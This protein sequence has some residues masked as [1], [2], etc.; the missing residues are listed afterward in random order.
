MK[1]PPGNMFEADR[2]V[3]DAFK[4][5]VVHASW[6][7]RR[8]LESALDSR[9]FLRRRATALPVGELTASRC[10]APYGNTASCLAWVLSTPPNLARIIGNNPP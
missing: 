10:G 3:V 9:S 7:R 8:R 1:L 4:R 5:V 6:T 2:D